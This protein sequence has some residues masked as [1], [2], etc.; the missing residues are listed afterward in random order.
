MCG[1]YLKILNLMTLALDAWMVFYYL[2]LHMIEIKNWHVC[3][4]FLTLI[5]ERKNWA[6]SV[7]RMR[8]SFLLC[9]DIS[10]IT[11]KA[12][13]KATLI[14]ECHMCIEIS[15]F[16]MCTFVLYPKKVLHQ[17]SPPTRNPSKSLDTPPQKKKNGKS[18][19]HLFCV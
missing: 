16:V 11:T 12:P 17:L 6:R 8:A 1:L 7:K 19:V 9:S 5:I 13:C 4:F 18:L 15:D 10:G 14:H 3:D 2:D